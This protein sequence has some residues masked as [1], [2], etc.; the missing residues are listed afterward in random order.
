MS[1]WKLRLLDE[2]NQEMIEFELRPA[3]SQ[4]PLA[5]LI[6]LPK[7]KVFADSA[8]T[9]QLIGPNTQDIRTFDLSC[10]GYGLECSFKPKTGNIYFSDSLNHDR[11]F[12]DS[13]GLSAFLVRFKTRGSWT[14]LVSEYFQVMVHPGDDNYSVNAMG[15]YTASHYD[16]LLYPSQT[17][18]EAAGALMSQADS[19][20]DKIRFVTLLQQALVGLLP[21]LIAPAKE[22]GSRIPA[23]KQM[24]MLASDPQRVALFQAGKSITLPK[25]AQAARERQ[26]RGRQENALILGLI[27]AVLQECSLLCQS[28]Q[29][30]V[31]AMPNSLERHGEYVSSSSYMT[32]ATVQ[33]LESM[34]QDLQEI[35]QDYGRLYHLFQKKLGSSHQP[36]TRPFRPFGLFQ[37]QPAYRQAYRMMG[38]WLS[39]KA[40]G[41]SDLRFMQTFLQIT[42]LYEV[43]VLSRLLQF[44]ADQEFTAQ[45]SRRI[46]YDM[47]FDAFYRN[48]DINNV[49]VL[50]KDGLKVTVYYQPVITGPHQ[51]KEEDCGLSRSVS[52]SFPRLFAEPYR[53]RY[54]T[55]D[56][57][58]RLEK[59]GWKGAR[60]ILADAKYC[61]FD[62]VAQHKI[63]PLVWKYLYS[64]HPDNK[65]DVI[66]GLYIFHGKKEHGSV[67][68]S[69]IHSLYDL[70][71]DPHAHFPQ[72]EIISLYE[73][74]GTDHDEQSQALATLF[75]LQI[76][77]GDQDNGLKAEVPKLEDL[78]LLTLSMGLSRTAA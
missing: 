14:S 63:I 8:Y 33:T 50:K 35:G 4:Q 58:I 5:D 41:G 11:I 56:Y 20:E 21:M 19:L 46:H 16:Q 67:E 61:T 18:A 62:D 71:D 26:D 32:R 78:N 59:E 24:Q 47:D 30:I 68:K 25:E 65:E 37:S 6:E 64:L 44:F 54:Y 3:S 66:S 42:T 51:K 77:K 15:R 2:Y 53:G 13:F 10:N 76:E 39:M 29:E 34:A 40:I 72:T 38:Q 48:T 28:M 9:A 55:P 23:A 43:Y 17:P 74:A 57:V 22:A 49:Y 7:K 69:L 60:Y 73:Y 1:S 70:L 36:F 45:A 12:A 27:E 52:L 75:S 31:R